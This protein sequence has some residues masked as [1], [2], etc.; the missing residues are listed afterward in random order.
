MA[1]LYKGVG[2]GFEGPFGDWNEQQR[3]PTTTPMALQQL[4]LRPHGI[5]QLHRIVSQVERALLQHRRQK[6]HAFGAGGSLVPVEPRRGHGF[7]AYGRMARK[8]ELGVGTHLGHAL[9]QLFGTADGDWVPAVFGQGQAGPVEG[10][11]D[12]G[13]GR[14][15][16]HQHLFGSQGIGKPP[17]EGV[18]IAWGDEA[19]QQQI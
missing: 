4:Q 6:G 10:V 15:Q 3:C 13:R 16:R 5:D 17:A 12:R 2:I 8:P 11:G 19:Q 18:E 7:H 1:Q 14:H 9:G